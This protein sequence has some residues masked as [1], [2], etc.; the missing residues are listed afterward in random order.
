MSRGARWLSEPYLPSSSVEFREC[1][2]DIALTYTELGQEYVAM[3][4][5]R[6]LAR[7]VGIVGSIERVLEGLAQAQLIASKQDTLHP[8]RPHRHY[9]GR[10]I[11]RLDTIVPHRTNLHVVLGEERHVS[12]DEL[13][14]AIRVEHRRHY[15]TETHTGSAQLSDGAQCMVVMIA[16][17]VRT[18]LTTCLACVDRRIESARPYHRAHGD[19]TIEQH[20]ATRREQRQ[21]A[22]DAADTATLPLSLSLGINRES[23]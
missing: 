4:R 1:E 15:E 12:Y 18:G 21:R 17:M 10:H 2:A 14:V 6:H 9:A 13:D 11:P 22:N 5:V 20:D 7:D 16:N 3:H 23:Y 8:P 19:W